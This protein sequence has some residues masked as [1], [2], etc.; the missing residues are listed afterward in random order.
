MAVV[1]CPDCN[2]SPVYCQECCEVL[3][4]SQTKR[5]HLI[6][7]TSLTAKINESIHAFHKRNS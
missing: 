1:Y 5:S 3:N 7:G 2:E 6:K 4:R